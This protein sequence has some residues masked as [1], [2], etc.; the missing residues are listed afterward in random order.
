MARM[1]VGAHIGDRAATGHA[2]AALAGGYVTAG[3][4]MRGRGHPLA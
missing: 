4:A 2:A 1:T 3:R